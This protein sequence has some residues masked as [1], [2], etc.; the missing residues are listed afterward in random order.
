M[1]EFRHSKLRK[2]L[3]GAGDVLVVRPIEGLASVLSCFALL[4]VP[5]Y[6]NATPKGAWRGHSIE[7]RFYEF[8]IE[9]LPLAPAHVQ[10]FDLVLDDADGHFAHD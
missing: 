7:T 8:T 2:R 1:D 4:E 6:A 5:L 9:K 10:V 3:L